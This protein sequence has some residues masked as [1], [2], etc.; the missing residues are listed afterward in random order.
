MSCYFVNKPTESSVS[1]T[2][3]SFIYL[4][5]YLNS[6]LEFYLP[7]DDGSVDVLRQRDVRLLLR[8]QEVQSVLD[9]SRVESLLH[10]PHLLHLEGSRHLQA[11]LQKHRADVCLSG[12]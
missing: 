5:I 6:A 2:A 11:G 8:V 10:Q 3:A 9:V 1:P 12:Q 4:F 7:G